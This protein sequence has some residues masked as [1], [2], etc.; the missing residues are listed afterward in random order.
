MTAMATGPRTAALLAGIAVAAAVVMMPFAGSASG[1]AAKSDRGCPDGSLCV[2]TK[3]DFEGKRVVMQKRR[4]T[5]RLAN[6]INDQASSLKLRKSGTAVLWEDIDGGG[7][8]YCFDGP[9]KA[10]SDLGKIGFDN[11]A[12]SS[13][14]FKRPVAC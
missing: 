3:P 4:R 14:I 9:R 13:K 5:N 7:V 2:W 12:S 10:A 6:T 1:P 8:A 11:Q